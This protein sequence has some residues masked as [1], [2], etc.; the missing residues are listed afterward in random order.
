MLK[1]GPEVSQARLNFPG[2]AQREPKG[3]ERVFKAYKAAQKSL[4]QSRILKKVDKTE[5]HPCIVERL[6]KI[7]SRLL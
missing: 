1:A 3:P 6:H 5:M 2:E 4:R 7:K